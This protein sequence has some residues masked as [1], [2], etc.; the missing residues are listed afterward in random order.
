MKKNINV[1]VVQNFITE[2]NPNINR[3]RV[4][5]LIHESIQANNINP[6]LILLPEFFTG[7]PWY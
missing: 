3:E 2:D 4:K 5:S 6:D 1:L 7:P